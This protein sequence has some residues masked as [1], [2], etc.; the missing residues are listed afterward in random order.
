M[1][2]ITQIFSA[3]GDAITGFSGALSNAITSITGMFYTAPSGSNTT[4][5]LTF[6]GVLLC[7]A[8]GMGLVYF[9]FRLIR[10]LIARRG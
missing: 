1:D 10:G 7:I 5:S 9:G 8:L 3:V 2:V 4:G 6:L